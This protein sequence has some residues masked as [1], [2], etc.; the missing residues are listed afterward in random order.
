MK[1]QRGSYK[2]LSDKIQISYH[3]PQVLV[4]SESCL[5]LHPPSLY[6][7]EFNL[8]ETHDILSLM[9]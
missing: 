6:V 1:M 3:T 7:P 8:L 9:H 2:K 5:T 4:S